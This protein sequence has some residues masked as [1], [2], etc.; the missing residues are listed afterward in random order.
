MKMRWF[1]LLSVLLVALALGF[2]AACDDD[3]D[4]DDSGGVCDQFCQ[5]VSE[6]SLADEI[7][8]GSMDECLVICQSELDGDVG[9]CVMN[10]NNC[11]EAEACFSAGDDDDDST[12]DDDDTTVDDDDDDDDSS[13]EPDSTPFIKTPTIH[14][15]APGF[16]QLIWNETGALREFG[17][18]EEIFLHV[19][20]QDDGCDLAGGKMYYRLDGGADV[21]YDTIPN[22][23]ECSDSQAGNDLVGYH[24][25]EIDGAMELTV[26]KAPHLFTFWWIDANGNVSNEKTYSYEVG[27]YSTAIGGTMASFET[28]PLVDKDGTEHYLSDFDGQIVVLNSFAMW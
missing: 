23:V 12:V 11:D 16:S 17:P 2:T 3:D 19:N 9:S 20:V 5:V 14:L 25:S 18:G 1:L 8:A 7:G 13:P 26:T 4:D 6:C 15:A 28:E 27:D 22:N 24:L 10:A 21:E